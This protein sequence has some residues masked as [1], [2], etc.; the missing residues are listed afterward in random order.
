MDKDRFESAYEMTATW[1]IPVPQPGFVGLE[2]AGA[3][4]GSVLD[5]GCGTGENAV[6]LAS[7]RHEVWGLDFVPEPPRALSRRI[8]GAGPS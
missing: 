4:H 6:Y 7:R 1:D 2:G 3:I 8:V 5:A